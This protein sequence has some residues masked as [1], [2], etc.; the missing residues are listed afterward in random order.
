MN[1][2]S[3]ILSEKEAVAAEQAAL[4]TSGDYVGE[5][6]QVLQNADHIR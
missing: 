2:E 6:V 3:V 4:T 1:E 5:N